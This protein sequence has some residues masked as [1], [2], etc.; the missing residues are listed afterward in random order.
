[1]GSVDP[2]PSS[3]GYNPSVTLSEGVEN[4]PAFQVVTSEAVA[5]QVVLNNKGVPYPQVAVDGYG[6]VQFPEGPYVPNN[7]SSLRPSFTTAYKEE[8]RQWWVGQGRTW[9]TAP[10]GSVINIHHIKP[11]SKGGTNAFENLIPLIQPEQ[12]QPFTNW[13]RGF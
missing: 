10:E 9:P 1:M 4:E 5:S 2:V 7:S 6:L 13:W 12:H 3:A 8:F 11:L